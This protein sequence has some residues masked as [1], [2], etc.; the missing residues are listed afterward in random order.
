MKKMGITMNDFAK[1]RALAL[2]KI[3]ITYTDEQHQI[4]MQDILAHMEEMGCSCSE[5]SVRRYIKQLRNELGVDIVS[6]RGRN[7][8]YFVSAK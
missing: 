3:L 7:A 8:R 5:D 2:Y 1:N 4:S 6:T